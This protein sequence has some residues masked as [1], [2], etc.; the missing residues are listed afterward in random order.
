MSCHENDEGNARMNRRS[1]LKSSAATASF[2]VVSADAVGGTKK[3][4]TLQ[5]GLIGCGNRGKWISD[6]FQKDGG[7]HLYAG[8]DYFQD[9]VDE[10]G[11]K[12][13]VP[14]K[15]RFTGLN[16]YKRLLETDVDAVAIM[17][18]PYFHPQQAL[19]AVQAGIHVYVAKPI[20]VDTPGCKTIRKAAQKAQGKQ[21]LLVDFQTRAN[22]YY[23]EALKRVHNGALGELAFG[24]AL[25]HA[26]DPF[27]RM[28]KW[29]QKD[30]VGAEE[31][32][33]AW[34]VFRSLS[35]DIITEQNIH[36]LDVMSWI[37][38]TP[39][40]C[41]SAAGNQVHRPHGNCYDNFQATFEYPDEVGIT[42]SSR[43]MKAWGSKPAGIRNRMFGTKGVL[44]TRYG[45]DVQILGGEESFYKGG[46]T[47]SIFKQGAVNNIETFRKNI[48][49]GAFD[50]PT[51]EPSI[52]STLITFLAR[53]AAYSGEKA[54]WEEIAEDDKRM[55]PDLEGLK[56]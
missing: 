22:K 55:Q 31:K 41:A 14:P 7:Y 25:Y 35:G 56:T 20:A 43:Q 4:S 40:L 50:N 34:G 1:F 36:T 33:R 44:E 53:K 26:R 13:D 48:A 8:A 54:Q 6:L 18:P 49:N 24:E 12:F 38:D 32:L 17:S 3:N 5:L 16:G 37:M 23:I 45:G 21:C 42:F 29:L 52:R 46:N 30:D 19:D 39:P 47:G 9:R 28:Y 15:R 51:V 10:F 27:G 2:A 11:K